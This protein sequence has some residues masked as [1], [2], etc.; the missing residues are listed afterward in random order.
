[1]NIDPSNRA[2]IVHYDPAFEDGR[3]LIEDVTIG[4]AVAGS[5]QI[6]TNGAKT[7]PHYCGS[8][9]SARS[10]HSGRPQS[11]LECQVLVRRAAGPHRDR[12]FAG[13]R[14]LYLFTVDVRGGSA[15]MS[16]PEVADMLLREGVYQ[17]LNLDGGGSTTMAME[18]P[19]T[20][21]R[22]IVNVSSDNP[23]GRAVGSSLRGLR[24]AC[25]ELNR[26][27]SPRLP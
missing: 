16:L 25:G 8:G 5:A 9:K 27:G 24:L 17:A 22:S 11:L 4:N 13:R 3:R 20:H 10:A 14:T 2:A 23:K 6:V 21:V 26:R 15:G 1:M 12:S 7:V 18:D 19:A